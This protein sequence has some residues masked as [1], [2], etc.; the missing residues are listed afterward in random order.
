MNWAFQ[1]HFYRHRIGIVTEPYPYRRQH[2]KTTSQKSILHVTASRIGVEGTS[3][4]DQKKA[5]NKQVAHAKKWSHYPQSSRYK[6]PHAVSRSCP[7]C[8]KSSALGSSLRTSCPNALRPKQK[9]PKLRNPKSALNEQ[10][11]KAT[12][13]GQAT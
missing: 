8:P 4:K 6:L 5:K 7:L 11:R 3:R 9:A 13:L 2:Q 1:Q 12:C 10:A